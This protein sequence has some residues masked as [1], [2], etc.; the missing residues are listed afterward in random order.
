MSYFPTLLLTCAFSLLVSSP[1]S[2]PEFC[3]Y[4]LCFSCSSSSRSSCVYSFVLEL[5]RILF[6]AMRTGFWNGSGYMTLPQLTHSHKADSR[7][8]PL[9]EIENCQFEMERS[10]VFVICGSSVLSVCSNSICCVCRRFL[11]ISYH[12]KRLNN[13]ICKIT[14]CYFSYNPNLEKASDST[15]CPQSEQHD[16]G[17][18]KEGNL[19]SVKKPTVGRTHSLPNDSYMFL[20]PQP[21]DHGAQARLIAQTEGPQHISGTPRSQ[22]GTENRAHN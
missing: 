17:E 5:F 8:R 20:S 6:I 3:L 14:M 4:P 18:S 16:L 9:K 7:D 12:S 19:L 1:R 22:S 15:F 13:S 21:C 10:L 11:L 2:F